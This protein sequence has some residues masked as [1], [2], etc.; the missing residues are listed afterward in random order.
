MNIFRGEYSLGNREF[1]M[2][3]SLPT[4]DGSGGMAGFSA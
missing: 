3:E 2:P 1:V 4:A